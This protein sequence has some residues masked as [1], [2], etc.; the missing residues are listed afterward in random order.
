MSR[1]NERRKQARSEPSPEY[2]QKRA[3]LLEAA[4]RVFQAKGFEGASIND[5]AAESGTDRATVYY[6]FAD[7]REVFH[8]VIA[9]AVESNVLTA[10]G[11][12][13]GSGGAA[14]KLRA[15]VTALLR[16][17][18]D[19]YPYLFVYIQ[20]DMA[21]LDRDG[22][23]PARRLRDLGRR[24]NSAVEAIIKSGIQAGEFR[25]GLDPRLASYAILGAVNWTHRWFR[26]G[27][28]PSGREVA[29][30]FNQIMLTGLTASPGDS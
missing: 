28:G 12:A 4:A 18:E 5:I 21:K 14:E 1:I 25:A 8:A 13:D 3:A 2:A 22:K 15:L 26:P 10:E 29:D 9:D 16:S 11:I 20:E 23:A 24:Y 17:Y 6:Y 7:K 19:H 30:V 27:K